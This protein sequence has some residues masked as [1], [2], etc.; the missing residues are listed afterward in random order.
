VTV[1]RIRVQVTRALNV[2]MM[3]LGE[4]RFGEPHSDDASGGIDSQLITADGRVQWTSFVAGSWL[5]TPGTR[6]VLGDGVTPPSP[7]IRADTDIG[8]SAYS[9]IEYR[10]LYVRPSL[11][12]LW[13]DRDFAPALGFYRRPGSARQEASLQFAPRPT[14]LGI[15]E[16]TFG[17]R[18]SIETTPEYDARLGQEAGSSAS[19]NWRNGSS[20][21]YGIASFVDDLQA[22]FVLYG[23][24]I[25]ADLYRGL[26]HSVGFTSPDRRALGV[27]GG[28][29]AFDLFGG[30]AH[31]PRLGVTARLGKHFTMRGSYTHIVGHLDRDQKFNFGFA[32][33][34]IDIAIDR[35]LAL[36]TLARLDLSPGRERFG[37][38]SRLRWRFAPG[39]DLFVV[40]RAERGF[41]DPDSPTAIETFHELTVKFT[42]YLR[43]FVDR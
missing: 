41:G 43:A 25:E 39:S 9:A 7:G 36:D 17:P 1:G 21:S 14:A 38:Q 18:Y 33:G 2:G 37:A 31:Q 23:Y 6:P 32:N 27:D 5:Q 26:R 40:Y 42:Y 34:N 22:P 8:S 16:V 10:G 15:R 11:L 4:H 20:L 3:L 35:N 28:Y 19:V 24:D 13:S 29:E 30:F 12:W